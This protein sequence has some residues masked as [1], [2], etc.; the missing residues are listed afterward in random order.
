MLLYEKLL[1]VSLRLAKTYLWPVLPERVLPG[2][3]LREVV[4]ND[5]VVGGVTALCTNLATSF[6]RSFVT[7]KVCSTTSTT[8]EVVKLVENAYAT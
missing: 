4:E 5:R 1:V 7:G 6:Y 2:Q 8:A 3:I